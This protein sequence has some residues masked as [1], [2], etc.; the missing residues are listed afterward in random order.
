MVHMP[1]FAA[2]GGDIFLAKKESGVGD[3]HTSGCPDLINRDPGIPIHYLQT[4]RLIQ[5]FYKIKTTY[6]FAVL[7]LDRAL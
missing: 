4:T 7:A 2:G 6:P 3:I 5:I 1:A